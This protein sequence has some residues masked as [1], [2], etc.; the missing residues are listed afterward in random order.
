MRCV[1]SVGPLGLQLPRIICLLGVVVKRWRGLLEL[2]CITH[3][4]FMSTQALLGGVCLSNA[5]NITFHITHV[6]KA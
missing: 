1:K 2:L 3:V 6:L 4:T 5:Q